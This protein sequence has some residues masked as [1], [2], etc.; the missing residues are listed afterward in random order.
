MPRDG[1]CRP[2][3]SER[4]AVPPAGVLTAFFR[5]YSRCSMNAEPFGGAFAEAL[6]D[7]LLL[8]EKGYP[9][10][11]ALTLVSDRYRLGSTARIALYRGADTRAAS[12]ARAAKLTGTCR[13]K[14]LAVDLFNVLFTVA[15]YLYGRTL[16]VSTDRFVRDNGEEFGRQRPGG[17][18][19]RAA[20][21]VLEWLSG[22]EPAEAVLYADGR[23]ET[24]DG[25]LSRIAPL[26]ASA[27]V[28]AI[29]VVSAAPDKELVSGTAE[30]IAT[31]DSV[32][33]SASAVPVLDAAGS[34]VTG[35][36]AADLPDLGALAG[37]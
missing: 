10:R 26:L 25:I 19:D 28:P 5:V 32:L 2:I 37:Y 7:Y 13:G 22:H 23:Y 30:A 4:R 35:Q 33:I 1:S 8:L 11:P 36:L 3:R 29:L 21:L 34:I 6:G 20:K 27:A 15:N 24:A 18:S 12:A 31:A 14:R 9:A 17:V 16:Y